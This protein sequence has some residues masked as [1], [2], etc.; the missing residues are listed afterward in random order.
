MSRMREMFQTD[1]RTEREGVWLD[2]GDFRIRVSRA[3]GSNKRYQKALEEESRQHR[4]A[5]DLGI[6]DNDLAED[7]LRR[8]YA[9]TVVRGWQVKDEQGEWQDGIEAEDGSLMP[10]TEENVLAT[11]RELPDL[12]ADVQEQA[13]RIALFRAKAREEASG[14]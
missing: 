12:F 11:F 7:L 3:G 6:M 1:D 2:Y 8:V 13:S 5:I 4:R 9:K 10:V 14:N